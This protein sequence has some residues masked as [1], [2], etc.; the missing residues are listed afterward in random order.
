[1]RNGTIKCECG[2]LLALSTSMNVIECPRCRTKHDVSHIPNDP[3]VSET[4]DPL[5]EKKAAVKTEIEA[6]VN[7][8]ISKM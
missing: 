5:E 6:I 1:M 3:D 4:L 8:I 2:Q 7:S